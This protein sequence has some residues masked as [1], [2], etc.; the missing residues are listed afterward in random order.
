[1]FGSLFRRHHDVP[2]LV[3]DV[4]SGTAAAAVALLSDHGPARIL[5]CARLDA[6]I[7]ARSAD[8][9]LTTTFSTLE[10]VA[11]QVVESYT[12]SEEHKKHGP[13]E[14]VHCLVGPSLS[15]SRTAKETQK[16][17]EERT[18]SDALIQELA[19]KALQAPSELDANNILETN[20]TRVQ[21]NGFPTGQPNGKRAVL[22]DVTALQSDIT[23]GAREGIEHALSVHAPGRAVDI[24]SETRATMT[25]LHERVSDT[26]PYL[27]IIMGSEATQ[28]IT[29][30]RDELVSH[31]TAPTGSAT[32]LAGL[33][34]E[35]GSP[36]ET[37][38]LLRMVANDACSDEACEN[39]RAN[40]AKTETGLVKTFGEVFA[41]LSA[42]RRVPNE[43]ILV[44]RSELAPWISGFFERLDF[45]QFSVT[46][47]PL[48][49]FSFTP[50]HLQEFVRRDVGAREDTG[51]GIAAAFVN[52]TRQHA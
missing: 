9:S 26:P 36:E 47:Q 51:T 2:I 31:A 20:V 23:A 30:R 32:I 44:T 45:S 40:L 15:R 16:F 39:M 27:L 41:Q 11:K 19:R 14:S 50:E 24:R 22:L 42:V 35:K 5:V 33:A 29:M 38:S 6:P 7:E 46:T 12:A 48:S 52:I 37:L 10:S 17:E 13:V 34:G 28:C 43:C 21:L 8:H 18:I 1:M 49:V 4:D 25:L 3:A